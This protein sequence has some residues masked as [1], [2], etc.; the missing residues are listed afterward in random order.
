MQVS[1]GKWGAV[2]G[3]ARFRGDVAIGGQSS[4]STGACLAKKTAP[5]F[6]KNYESLR[7]QTGF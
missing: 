3:I 1:E 5:I 4:M 7:V 2:S 6:R